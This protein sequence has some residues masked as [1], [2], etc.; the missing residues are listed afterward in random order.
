MERL[1]NVDMKEYTS[2]RAGG[3]AD[4]MLIPETAEELKHALRETAESGTDFVPPCA[5]V[6]TQK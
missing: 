5:P 2:F 6:L 4:L 3:K 1:I